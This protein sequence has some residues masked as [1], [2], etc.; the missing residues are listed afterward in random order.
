[1]A[2]AV[3]TPGFAQP[4]SKLPWLPYESLDRVIINS[5]NFGPS[6]PLYPTLQD[7]VAGWMASRDAGADAEDQ[8]GAYDGVLAN[9][10]TRVDD[11]GL[12]YSFDGT[13]DHIPISIPSAVF[14][15]GFSVAFWAKANFVWGGTAATR[16]PIGYGSNENIGVTN[17]HVAGTYSGAFFM[18]GAGLY[19]V[20]LMSPKPAA[21][22]WVHV[23]V[24]WDGATMRLYV[25]GSFHSSVSNSSFGP[26]GGTS[27][28]IGRGSA[29]STSFPGLMDDILIYSRPITLSEQASL[30][31]VRGAVY[32]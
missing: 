26:V 19:P 30:A 23:C 25:D 31:T 6:G 14:S 22:T 12:A 29:A 15:S 28:T 11:G 8:F 17:Q 21:N 13:N 1:L 9:G 18:R 10:A 16:Y 27:F 5:H 24:T 3:V 2:G 4:R 32:L 7:A 20:T